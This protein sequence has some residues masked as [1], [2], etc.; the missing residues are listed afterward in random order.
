M[1]HMLPS[2]VAHMMPCGAMVLFV[3]PDVHVTLG[4]ASALQGCGINVNDDR[5]H[6]IS[7]H[8]EILGGPG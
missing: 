4:C 1:A 6:P 7:G 3:A 5:E 8:V 2:D